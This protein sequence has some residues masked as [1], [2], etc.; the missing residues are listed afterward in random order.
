MSSLILV[1]NAVA[2][3]VHVYD[4]GRKIETEI[5]IDRLCFFE[6]NSNMVQLMIAAKL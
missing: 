3:T 6:V 1:G 4:Y 5:E 2:L